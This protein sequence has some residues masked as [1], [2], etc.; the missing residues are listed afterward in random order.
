MTSVRLASALL[1]L[2]GAATLA[3]SA[4]ADADPASDYLIGQQVFFPYDV[5]LPQRDQAEL[6]AVV[7]AA[8]RA[9]F[10]IRVAIIADSYDLGAVTA[11]WKRPRFY[12][13]FLG[14][15]LA[16]VYKQ[17]LLVVMPSG[18]GF[19]RTG[20]TVSR[21]YALLRRI[22]I[23][24][25]APGLLSAAQT[26]VQRLAAADGVHVATPTNVKGAGSQTSHDRIVIIVIA[27]AALLVAV[28]VRFALR[29]RRRNL[30]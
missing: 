21:E 10:K 27:V 19:Y 25:G 12:A 13:R 2:V 20:H 14:Q 4:R 11:L 15:E 29:R 23:P 7:A 30:V 3:G 24:G 28:G 18:F 6:S 1:A 9:G 17:R 16:F 26:A 22:P 8:N 5:K